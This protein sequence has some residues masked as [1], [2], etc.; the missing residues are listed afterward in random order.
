M[1]NKIK[2]VILLVLS[3]TVVILCIIA[4]F[5]N[6]KNTIENIGLKTLPRYGRLYLSAEQPMGT[7]VWRPIIVD[8]SGNS[9]TG[10]CIDP[11]TASPAYFAPTYFEADGVTEKIFTQNDTFTGGVYRNSNLYD[12]GFI[13]SYHD[14]GEYDSDNWSA[15]VQHAIWRSGVA[16]KYMTTAKAHGYLAYYGINLSNESKWY[17][18]F[19]EKIVARSSQADPKMN[20]KDN[21]NQDNIVTV[22]NEDNKTQRIGPFN[23]NYVNQT[24]DGKLAKYGGI[25]DMYLVDD[26]ENKIAITK[27]KTK[28]MHYCYSE[29]YNRGNIEINA[30]TVNDGSINVNSL[31]QCQKWI[32]WK[33][34][35]I[36][37]E[38]GDP[39]DE[40]HKTF[41]EYLTEN[42]VEKIWKD[43]GTPCYYAVNPNGDNSENANEEDYW[44]FM[45]F[46]PDSDED[47]YVEYDQSQQVVGSLHLHVEFTWLKCSGSFIL[48]DGCRDFPLYD[49][50]GHIIGYY[51][52]NSY[53]G[54][55]MIMEGERVPVKE[56][57][58]IL[59]PNKDT[60]MKIGGYVFEDEKTGKETLQNGI[61]DNSDPKLKNVQVTLYQQNTAGTLTNAQCMTLL[62]T[63][64]TIPG[65]TDEQK[66][67]YKY[68]TN[69][70]IKIAQNYANSLSDTRLKT[71]I[72]DV[73]NESQKETEYTTR[74]NPTL[75][76]DSGYYEF[77]GLDTKNK[78]VVKFTYNGQNYMPTDYLTLSSTATSYSSVSDMVSKGTYSKYDKNGNREEN[79]AWQLTS[80]GTE[81]AQER[82]NYD[83]KFAQIGSSPNNYISSNS[84]G[85]LSSSFNETYTE[86]QLMGYTLNVNGQ[87]KQ[88]GIQ[89]IDGYLK[90]E[91]GDI[92]TINGEK[93]YSEGAITKNIKEFI[94]TNKQYPNDVQLKS[95]YNSIVN[96]DMSLKKKVQFIEDCKMNSWT[97]NSTGT[98]R[99]NRTSGMDQYPVYNQFTTEKKDIAMSENTNGR[100]S[101]SYPG[102]TILGNPEDKTIISMNT[103]KVVYQSIYEG[104]L[105][106]NQGLWRRQESDAALRKDVYKAAVKVNGKTEVYNYNKR[107]EANKD[108]WDIQ[109]RMSDY[110]AYYGTGYT[111]ELYKSD[112]NAVTNN[113]IS[114]KLEVYVTYKITVRNQSQ[115]VLMQ[116]PEV[117]DYYDNNYTYQ[118][119]LSWV[120]YD[121]VNDDNYYTM[122][123]NT[124]NYGTIA[125]SKTTNSNNDSIYGYSTQTT[126]NGYK[127]LYVRGLADKKL[128]SGESAYIYLTFK[129]NQNN[130]YVITGN[131]Q[132]ISE[133]NG[134]N[135]YYKDGTKLPNNVI[136]NSS[137]VAGIIDRDS[138]PGNLTQQDIDDNIRY[139][140]NFEDD[141]DRAKTI[142]ITVSNENA[143]KINGTVWE[144]K[145]TE[146]SETNYSQIGNGTKDKGEQGVGNVT[147]TLWDVDTNKIAKYWDGSN[148]RD[149]ITISAT[150]EKIK[151]QYA[152]DGYLAG[153]YIEVF[154]YGQDGNQQYNG[155][156]YKSTIY[157]TQDNF[158]INRPDN[159]DIF[160][161]LASDQSTTE[162]SYARDYNGNT[163]TVK[164]RQY[165]NNYSNN[166]GN[167]VTNS[168]AQTLKDSSN[169][170]NSA[171]VMNA[172]TAK[173]IAEVEYGR[174]TSTISANLKDNSMGYTY[175]DAANNSSNYITS[176]GYTIN[177]LD[178]GLTERPKAQLELLKQVANVKVTLANGSTLFDASQKATNAMWV[179]T[180]EIAY[181]GYKDNLM[182]EPIVRKEDS[183]KGKVQLT[184]DSELMHG[185]TIKITYA[186][187]AANTGEVDY[188]DNEFYYLGKESDIADNIVKTKANKVIDYVGY[189]NTD[190]EK[191][192]KNNLKFN[193]TENNDY[194]WSVISS[195]DLGSLS[196]EVQDKSKVY[197]TIITNNK[198]NAELI[199]VLADKNAKNAISAATDG[200]Y[201]KAV[202]YINGTNNSKFMT[203]TLLVLSQTLSSENASDDMT[204]NN[205]VEITNTNNTVGR[206]MAYSVAGNQDPTAQPA[207]ADTDDAEEIVILPPFG[208]QHYIYYI[209]GA[210][211]AVILIAGVIIIKKKILKK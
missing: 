186:I 90:N 47:F 60:T 164:T 129:V 79:I 23:V 45:R 83:A 67:L 195:D 46:Y 126:L 163:S 15:S 16:R 209:L 173:I 86:L 131:K 105:E 97:K 95:I 93:I 191:A 80:K 34:K 208:Q 152:F 82:S 175:Q 182:K 91:N 180:S 153:N 30:K 159:D 74:M 128:S 120:T 132:N 176:G 17:Q 68:N 78:Y 150:D 206:R 103:N 199:P 148:W 130:S 203:A 61:M 170:Y 121:S 160:N 6:T 124:M 168:L 119:K 137:D 184:M 147:V 133:I 57:L 2:N 143:R 29:D 31:N 169:T 49:E 32:Y 183:K 201:D 106:I 134:Y 87:Y 172:R 50:D 19:Y 72:Q 181:K 64:F 10:Y 138:N 36:S 210:G 1:K 76:N 135:T 9:I 144:D 81:D 117:V 88:T 114:N 40:N 142:N 52:D 33:W 123:S 11:N 38:I 21:T 174:N 179:N 125:N 48:R 14:Y 27:I 198:L 4:V 165:V 194:G 37:S 113:D 178:F 108:Y 66:N 118:E 205:M 141:T 109:V 177:K 136:K 59:W 187:F 75:T 5:K 71:S 204:Y 70:A 3:L 127:S 85:Y 211:I 39:L 56:S 62:A 13:L 145:R 51:T 192:T 20:A 146:K 140:K 207:E 185:A 151:G 94:K 41:E 89:L 35:Y 110:D 197:S 55:I 158:D 12:V 171:L 102:E 111:R 188:K 166:G 43:Y 8:E 44:D 162:T 73:I 96:N 63:K 7:L 122:M 190:D 154:T 107:D 196:K 99:N 200:S 149:A 22:T 24:N 161:F 116:I 157:N 65:L 77:R 156:D 26:A 112:Y 167:G 58:D 69:E 25:S 18:T 155:Q 92:A 54:A 193:A 84:L 42:G 139:E 98:V 104:Q 100:V 53:Q 115:S 101:N 28:N 202:D 189:Q